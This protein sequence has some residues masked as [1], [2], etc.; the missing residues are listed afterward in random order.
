[1]QRNVTLDILKALG[2]VLVIIGHNVSGSVHQ[3]IYSFHMPMFFLLAGYLYKERDILQSIKYDFTRILLPYLMFFGVLC[4][5]EYFKYEISCNRFVQDV[6]RVVWGSVVRIDIYGHHVQGVGY[7]WFLPALFICKN[8]FNIIFKVWNALK[9]SHGMY[10]CMYVC[11]YGGIIIH[12][13]LFPL[14]FAITTGLNALGYYTLGYITKIFLKDISL[15]NKIKWYYKIM[16]IFVWLIIG[17][18][19][20]NGMGTCDYRCIP[21]DYIAA[22]AG[23]IALFY[24]ATFIHEKLKCIE[25]IFS[26]YG[27]YTISVL[28]IHQ[29]IA[30]YAYLLQ[31]DQNNLL[32]IIITCVLSML[33][34][35]IHYMIKQKILIK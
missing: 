31:I 28:I 10:V 11:M 17:R 15:I 13:K 24:V 6:L 33:Y 27:Q 3:Y 2:I 22:I 12:H 20:L 1:M 18:S 5:I 4:G 35:I 25:H 8:V 29:F 16:I 21:L 19:A 30:S 32:L 14:P 23:S 7:L 9:L 34:V 26:I